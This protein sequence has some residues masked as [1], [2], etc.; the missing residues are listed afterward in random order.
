MQ[1]VYTAA[2]RGGNTL[3]GF[4]DV[5]TENGSS[6]GQNL[7]LTGLLVPTSLDRGFYLVGGAGNSDVFTPYLDGI[8]IR[9]VTAHLL[10]R[11]HQSVFFGFES[12][13]GSNDCSSNND[14]LSLGL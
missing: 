10:S 8:C 7:A 5:R 1:Y 2:E 6:Q 4:K 14:N 11:A 13:N 9:K 3:K 12:V